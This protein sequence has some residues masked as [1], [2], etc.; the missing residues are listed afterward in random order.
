M[1][2][3]TLLLLFFAIAPFVIITAQSRIS[4]PSPGKSVVYF[5][6]TSGMGAIVNFTY[7]DS[8]SLI[9]R[10]SG[11][12]YIRYECEPG[13]HFF[14]A[15]SENRDFVEAELAPDK[16]YFILAYVGMGAVK[17]SVDLIPLNPA[18]DI[19]D[20]ER[21]LKLIDKQTNRTPD[22]EQLR[23]DREELAPVIERGLKQYATEQQQGYE[24]DVLPIDWIYTY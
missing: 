24:H 19:K 17:A 16:V 7:C 18:K 15:R 23:S 8:A 12:G 14:W 6:R 3:A 20:M 22:E 2:K 21:I 9:G 11:P 4:P 13:H 5:A 10:F 1:K